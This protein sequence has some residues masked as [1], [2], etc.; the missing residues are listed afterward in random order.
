[1]T[2]AQF[3]CTSGQSYEEIAAVIYYQTLQ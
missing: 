1:M 2:M 3:F